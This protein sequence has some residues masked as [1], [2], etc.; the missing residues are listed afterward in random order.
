MDDVLPRVGA[1]RARVAEL[2]SEGKLAAVYLANTERQTVL[3]VINVDT[4]EEATSTVA[5]PMSAWWGPQCLPTQHSRTTEGRSRSAER[6]GE[7]KFT[8]AKCRCRNP[9]T[10]DAHCQSFASRVEQRDQLNRVKSVA[11]S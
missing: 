9:P 5:T 7:G 8:T 1:E 2:E 10:S 4:V 3:L 6:L 11:R